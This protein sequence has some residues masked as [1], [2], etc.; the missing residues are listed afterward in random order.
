[1]AKKIFYVFLIA[2]FTF[3]IIVPFVSYNAYKTAVKEKAFNHLITV[4]DLLKLQIWNYFNER[5]GDIDVLSRNPVI[6][7]GF[8]RLSNAVHTFGHESSQFSTVVDLYQP[9]MEY[10]VF[11]YGYVN[12]FFIDKDG[13]VM[14]SAIKEDF[15]GTNLLTGTYKHNNIA[16]VFKQGLMEVNFE[17][18]T[19]NGAVSEF[20]SYFAAPVFEANELLGAL[21]IEIPFSH[22]DSMLT[23]RTGLGKTGEMYLVGD[24]GFMRSNSRF[25]VKP[26]MLQKEVDTKATREAFEGYVG[27]MLMKDYRGVSVLSA[28][29]PLNLNFMNWVLLV[30]MDEAEAFASIY[31]VELKLTVIASIIGFIAISYLYLEFK[32]EK[33][34]IAYDDSEDSESE[35]DSDTESA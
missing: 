27:T 7:Q 2:L 22:L 18:Y 24:D 23:Q 17:D 10:Y 4:R 14:F 12:I 16:R 13:D 1:M 35:E 21:I 29:T 3:L 19:W 30:E 31:S 8:T 20:T 25:S 26:T 5:Y 33:K 15:T 9:L 34:R 11:D 32:K 28:Y 6:A